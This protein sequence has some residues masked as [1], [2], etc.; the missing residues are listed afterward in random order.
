MVLGG[1]EDVE[2][3]TAHG[4]VAALLDHVHTRVCRGRQRLD[5]VLHAPRLARAGADGLEVAEALHDGLQ[6]GAHRDHEDADRAGLGA[7]GA[8]Q[9]VG[10][11]AVRGGGGRVA[12][13]GVRQ[14]PQDREA[15][16][17]GVAARAE[18]LVRERLPGGEH[19]D[20]VGREEGAQ[21]AGE[22]VGVPAGRRHDD[23]WARAT[24][25]ALGLPQGGEQRCARA[26]RRHD[27]E[28]SP[29][30]D[31]EQRGGDG[32]VLGE[33]RQGGGELH[34][35]FLIGA[36]GQHDGPAARGPSGARTGDTA[37]W[38]SLRTATDIAAVGRSV[39]LSRALLPDALIRRPARP[40]R[41]RRGPR[42]GARARTSRAT[43]RG[44]VRSRET[45][46]E[47]RR[48]GPAARPAT[49]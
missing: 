9:V 23:E 41:A 4:E 8:G 16:G 43:A 1:R 44:G 26:R 15:A 36:C 39:G 11:G 13:L 49:G 22:L 42:A 30:A 12:D 34:Q 2:D 46:A 18:A 25:R 20:V 33:D 32:G 14:A 6:Q 48:R 47:P 45:G 38:T 17:D 40:P 5:E 27:L 28:I 3:P 31:G 37:T 21:G 29:G 35:H 10:G 19:R 7:R 24:T